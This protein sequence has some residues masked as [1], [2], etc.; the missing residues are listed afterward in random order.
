[1]KRKLKWILFL[2]IFVGLLS[3]IAYYC[4]HTALTSY[5]LTH[6]SYTSSAIPES[7][8]GFK[9]AFLS[10]IDL[11]D[12][13]DLNRFKRICDDLNQQNPNLV[14]LGGD[15]FDNGIFSKETVTEI[16]KG[17]K[18]T[19]GKFAV[20]GEK[21]F[22][23]LNEWIE[24]VE[25]GGFEVLR[26]Q[27]QRL[28]YQ[29]DHIELFGLESMG[30]LSSLDQ[31]EDIFKLVVVHEPDYFKEVSSY[32]HVV[33]LSGHSH[34]G[35]IY[36]PYFGAI[37]KRDGASTYTHGNYRILDNRLYISNGIGHESSKTIR[38]LT[39]PEVLI[40][41]LNHDFTTPSNIAET[42]TDLPQEDPSTIE[43][44]DDAST[45]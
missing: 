40:I 21:D 1:M 30:T 38:F 10:D 36:I 44:G 11:K 4:T 19:H 41:T 33:Q 43:P 2:L 42:P 32:Q 28:Y 8:Q 17:I 6:K 3:Y 29:D 15:L 13:E 18:T 7:F 25:N 12:E 14:I 16:L 20:L 22:S 37:V 31:S 26:N 5:Q 23:S 9:I 24:L 27:K 34:G 45:S 35:Y 39:K